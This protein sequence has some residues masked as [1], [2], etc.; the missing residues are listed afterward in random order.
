MDKS[1]YE[2]ERLEELG[3]LPGNKNCFDCGKFLIYFR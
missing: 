2:N 3:K 1:K